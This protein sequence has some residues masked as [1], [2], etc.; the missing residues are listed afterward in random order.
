MKRLFFTFALAA[1]VLFASELS[2]YRL[3]E[4][5]VSEVD[6]TTPAE[7]V[8]RKYKSEMDSLADEVDLA[9]IDEHERNLKVRLSAKERAALKKYDGLKEAITFWEYVVGL[10]GSLVS[11]SNEDLKDSVRS[12]ADGIA[13]AVVE[14][15]YRASQEYEITGSALFHNFLINTGVKKKGRCYHYVNDLKD[16]LKEIDLKNFELHWGEAYAGTF[17]ENN[18]LVVTAKG[19]PFEDG[20]AIDAWRSAGKPFWIP[21][22]VDK[23][24]PWVETANVN[25]E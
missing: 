13:K 23:H 4:Y 19:K 21:V 14:R 17:R 18:A 7:N 5:R 16:A 10:K 11:L 3:P 25:Y 15:L 20:I 12:E 9:K 8:L 1:A 24:Y 22:S 2:A 6:S